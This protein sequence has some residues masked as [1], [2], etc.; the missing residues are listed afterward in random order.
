MAKE[1]RA[2]GGEKAF[3]KDVPWP[4]FLPGFRKLSTP[5]LQH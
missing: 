2:G 3:C 5:E 1:S 4:S